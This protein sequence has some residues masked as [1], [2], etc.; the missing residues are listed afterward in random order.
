M[1]EL[2]YLLAAFLGIYLIETLFSMWLDRLN[3]RHMQRFGDQ[4]P[5]AFEGIIDASQ[6]SRMSSYT[7]DKSRIGIFRE[8][9][10]ELLLLGLILSGFLVYLD[11]LFTAWGLHHIPAGILFFMTPWLFT[12]IAELPFSYYN[13]FVTEEKYGFNR[14]TLKIWVLDHLKSLAISLV[15]FALLLSIVLWMIQLSPSYWW[16]WGFLIVSFIQ[17]MLA[18]LYP[19]VIAPMFNKFE[20]IRDEELSEKIRNLMEQN[21]IKVKNILEMNAGLRSRH[22]NAYFTGLGKTKQIVLFDTLIESHT[23]EEILAVLAHEVGHFKKK[24]ILKQLLLF[25]VSTLIGFYA[26]HLFL[27][28]PLLYETFGFASMQPYAGLFFI[29]IFLQKSAFLLHPFF[30][31]LSR[32]FERQSDLFA[33]RFLGTSQ[34]LISAL[35]K[36]AVDNL[37]NLRPHPLYVKFNY[38]H[39][40]LLERIANLEKAGQRRAD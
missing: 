12:Y 20:P 36:M 8:S 15:L 38:S 29:G 28:W 4:I 13:A 10:S 21:G 33:A 16:F 9:I 11:S 34:P 35:K 19:V 25:E 31:G 22:T 30:M 26:T 24:H 3:V 5:A 17:L 1:V 40:P 14:S 37:S 2:N 7:V 6:L 18:V 27:D 23:H 39:P 32:Y